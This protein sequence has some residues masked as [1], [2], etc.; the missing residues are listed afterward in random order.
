MFLF[1][2]PMG[3]T[4]LSG[5]LYH[6]FQKLTPGNV[7]PMLTLAV[8]YVTAAVICFGLLAIYPS[9]TGAIE[10]L[11][12]LNWASFA[13]A[14]AIIGLEIGFLLVYR[15]GWNISLVA[16]VS[17]VAVTI[18]LVPVGLLVFKEKVSLVNLIGIVVCIVG[19]VM[20]NQK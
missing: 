11:R 16:I 13:L 18:V 10:S 14:L 1:Y 20:V 6:V 9:K 17:N 8:T 5:A 4:V 19:L 2:F 12:Q 3:L 15:A 7:N